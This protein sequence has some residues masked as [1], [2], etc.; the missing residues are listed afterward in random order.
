[1][2]EVTLHGTNR[3]TIA[4]E[5]LNYI[6]IYYKEGLPVRSASYPLRNNVQRRILDVSEVRDTYQGH[7]TETFHAFTPEVRELVELYTMLYPTKRIK[8]SLWETLKR[9][10]KERNCE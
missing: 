2:Y 1:M 7:T 10:Y 5:N 8:L 3:E 6:E 4:S 9:W